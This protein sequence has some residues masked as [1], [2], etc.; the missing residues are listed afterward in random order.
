MRIGMFSDTYTPQVNGVVTSI[1]TV[2]QELERQG[3]EVFVFAPRVKK[4]EQLDNVFYFSSAPWPTSPE[5]HLSFPYALHLSKF[6]DLKLDIIHSHTPFSLGLLAVFLAKKYKIPI[7][8][9]YHTLFTEY[10]HYV[11]LLG[12]TFVDLFARNHSRRYCQSCHRVIVPSSAMKKELKEWGVKKPIDVIP[13]G[14]D[15]GPAQQAD[16]SLIKQRYSIDQ[17]TKVMI[18]AGRLAKEKNITF[19]LKVLKE[20]LLVRKD[21]LF[22]IMGDG[23]FRKNL[24][25]YVEHNGLSNNV[26]FTGYVKDRT[27]LY[28]WMNSADLFVFSSLTET[29]GLVV[30]EAMA[31]GTPVVAVNAMGVKDVI[32]DNIGGIS[33]E[34]DVTEFSLKLNYLLTD[35]QLRKVKTQEAANKVNKFTIEKMTGKIIDIYECLIAERCS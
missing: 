17:D 3:H 21:L 29:Q 30:L 12:Q 4:T 15:V 2:K 16:G 7:V 9:T 23:P 6:S 19:L 8:H 26:L 31:A 33:S 11:P 18:Y 32:S 22:V 20:V 14:I 24:E 5:H 25:E 1:N 34:L 10:V 13:T 35:D 27:H 28:N